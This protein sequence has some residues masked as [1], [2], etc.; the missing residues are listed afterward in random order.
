MNKSQLI[1]VVKQKTD[2]TKKDIEVIV[3]TVFECV[4][5]ALVEG[6]KVAIAGFGTFAVRARVERRGRN[7]KT[8]EEIVVPAA[9]VPVFRPFKTLKEA[10]DK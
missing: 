2:L 10:I 7:P 8:Q 3:N 6:D 5:E 4:E 1:D 9:K